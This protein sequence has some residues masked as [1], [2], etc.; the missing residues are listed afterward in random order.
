MGLQEFFWFS[1]TVNVLEQGLSLS[2]GILLFWDLMWVLIWV[3]EHS[4]GPE[5]ELEELAQIYVGRGL[6]YYLAKQVSETCCHLHAHAQ[7]YQFCD[8]WMRLTISHSARLKFHVSEAYFCPQLRG[9]VCLQCNCLTCRVG[10]WIFFPKLVPTDNLPLALFC[11]MRIVL[12]VSPDE[13]FLSH[14]E[15]ISRWTIHNWKTSLNNGCFVYLAGCWRVNKSGCTES[16]CA[17]WTGNRLRAAF[18][19]HASS[20]GLSC[21]VL[22]RRGRTSSLRLLHI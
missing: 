21:G 7:Q 8:L 3:Q 17:R 4:Q 5:A 2:S 9:D 6:T 13:N 14:E 16:A 20:P 1:L 15:V 11:S 22:G 12:I 10:S 19:P 18:Q